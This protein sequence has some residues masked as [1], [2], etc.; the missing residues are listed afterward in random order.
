MRPTLFWP[1]YPE[2]G[3]YNT[4]VH[5][6]SHPSQGLDTRLALSQVS[7]ELGSARDGATDQPCAQEHRMAAGALAAMGMC[8]PTPV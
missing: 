1:L 8:V 2:L 4:Q 6:C 3:L 5:T 7:L